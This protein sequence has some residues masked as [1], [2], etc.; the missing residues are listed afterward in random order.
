MLFASVSKAQ[1][2]YRRRFYFDNIYGV[3]L[4]TVIPVA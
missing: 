3:D 2:R 1:A 4:R